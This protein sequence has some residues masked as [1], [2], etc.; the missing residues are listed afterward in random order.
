MNWNAIGAVGQAVS[1]LALVLVLMQ[2]SDARE[3][4]QRTANRAR[5]EGTRDMFVVQ[6]TTPELSGALRRANIA[7]RGQQTT[8][9]QYL[10]GLGLN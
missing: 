10:I 1:A 4:M 9:I 5:L 2:L 7:A 6:A 8:D 3:E